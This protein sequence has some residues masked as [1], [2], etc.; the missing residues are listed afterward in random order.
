MV[1]VH[2]QWVR[3]AGKKENNKER[4]IS[5]PSKHKHTIRIFSSSYLLNRVRIFKFF[6]DKCTIKFIKSYLLYLI[7]LIKF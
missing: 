6:K 2:N 3:I 4:E 7:F 1:D 5:K